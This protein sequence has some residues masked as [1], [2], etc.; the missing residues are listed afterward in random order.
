[1][2]DCEDIAEAERVFCNDMADQIYEFYEQ[3]KR[4]RKL[5]GQCPVC[6]CKRSGTNAAPICRKCTRRNR[7][8]ESF[9][10]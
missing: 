2:A 10:W 5:A 7:T 6:G 1:M 4:G 8:T 3:I 9:V